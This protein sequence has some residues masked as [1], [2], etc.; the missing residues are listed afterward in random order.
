VSFDRAGVDHPSRDADAPQLSRPLSTYLRLPLASTPNGPNPR[1]K[2]RRIQQCV[3]PSLA[4]MRDGGGFL[5]PVPWHLRS[6]LRFCAVNLSHLR[7]FFHLH[8]ITLC[9]VPHP[10]L[11][12]S[13][14]VCTPSLCPYLYVNSQRVASI[15]QPLLCND[16]P[17]PCARVCIATPLTSN[18]SRG[19]LSL[20]CI[21]CTCINIY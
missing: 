21:Y 16:P 6:S 12:L 8:P 18:T 4:Q 2:S 20:D 19:L 17:M 15:P 3:T 13:P 10:V 5:V 7:L 11:C 14:C 9:C 1:P